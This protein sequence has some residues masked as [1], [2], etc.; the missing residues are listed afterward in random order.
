MTGVFVTG[1]DTGIGKTL[2]AAWLV[3]N[4]RASYWKPVQSGVADGSDAACVADL[5]PGTPV[6]P[7]AYVLRA[8]LSPHEAAA[9]EGRRIDLD[10]FTLPAASPLVVEG[11]GG[12]LVP[13]N[14]T[15]T[16]ADLMV[17]LGLPVLV[18]A[19]STLGTINHTLLTLEALAHRGLTVAGV[20]LNGPP[21]PA[22]RRAIEQ[23]GR[24]AV[25][26][27]LPP[28]PLVDAAGLDSLPPPTFPPPAGN[29]P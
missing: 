5:A 7:S 26:A 9:R 20:V 2:V 4:W 23:Y 10:A 6:H 1:T 11:A 24:V 13:L 18:V 28:L 21:N 22:N 27:E 14:E 19:R 12:V 25:L 16:M 17:R 29:T 3:R 8:P 15:A